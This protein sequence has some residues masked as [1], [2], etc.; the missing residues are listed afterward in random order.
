MTRI[1]ETELILPALY[2]LMQSENGMPMSELIESLMDLLKPTGE[3]MQILAGRRDTK[4]SQKVRN[5]RSHNTL[6]GRGLALVPPG[7][8]GRLTIT[9][10]GM[11]LVNR[12]LPELDALFEFQFDDAAAE[13]SQLAIDAPVIVLDERIVTEG[14][15]RRRTTEYK[16]RSRELRNAALET[17]AVNGRID[18]STCDFDF[19]AAYPGVGEGYIQIHHLKPVAFMEGEPLSMRDALANVRP[20]C[21]NCHQMV[22]RRH[23]PMPLSVLRAMLRVSYIYS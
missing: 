6:S 8:G 4:F 9:D 22:H 10:K 14:E 18:C 15:L 16:T 5:L 7:R 1:S 21:A 11:Q 20:L 3:D 19:A 13:L 23:P 17:F 12:H 2:L